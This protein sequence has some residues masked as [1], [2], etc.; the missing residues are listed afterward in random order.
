MPVI[1]QDI[2]YWDLPL[3]T[4]DTIMAVLNTAANYVVLRDS[5]GYSP[6]GSRSEEGKALNE[7]VKEFLALK[8]CHPVPPPL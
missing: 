2:V 1:S 6:V 7:A 3:K 4:Y 8:L 5:K